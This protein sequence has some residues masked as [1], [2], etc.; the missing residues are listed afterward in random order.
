MSQKVYL[1]VGGI[2]F[3]VSLDTLQKC[4]YF[5]G[6]MNLYSAN[7]GFPKT[8]LENPY[9]ID[10]SGKAFEHVLNFIRYPDYDFFPTK[11]YWVLP[12]WGFEIN[13]VRDYNR[14]IKKVNQTTTQTKNFSL[15]NIMHESKFFESGESQTGECII[16]RHIS[17]FRKSTKSM[18]TLDGEKFESIPWT[19]TLKNH[20]YSILKSYILI[21]KNVPLEDMKFFSLK[22]NVKSQHEKPLYENELS[23]NYF[24]LNNPDKI[25]K[26]DG[27]WY[28]P[29]LHTFFENAPFVNLFKISLQ[30]TTS[31]SKYEN[32]P[33]QIRIETS[34]ME[35]LEIERHADGLR[36]Q[37]FTH[38][39][40]YNL[41]N[42][43]TVILKPGYLRY[44]LW[45]CD[46][47]V[48]EVCLEALDNNGK[49]LESHTII[50]GDFQYLERERIGLKKLPKGAGSLYYCSDIE[51]CLMNSGGFQISKDLKIRLKFPQKMNGKL[52]QQKFI[53]LRKR[54]DHLYQ[55][56]D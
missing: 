44:I 56:G 33:S 32:L 27:W 37:V 3:T 43:D 36:E 17:I 51:D 11:Y 53:V 30:L 52:W 10:H 14:E 20:I 2:P 18:Y 25:G 15:L 39:A 12:F 34:N 21:P 35:T 16:T 49:I 41:E 46:E 22:I 13:D 50:R 9:F 26:I 19:Y 6:I 55:V 54:G 24:V 28:L 7:T 48:P 23:L 40:Q 45:E 47:I 4:P 8:T 31:N 29:N 1:D 5:Q 42:V 38:T